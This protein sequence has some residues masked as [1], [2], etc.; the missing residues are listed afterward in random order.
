MYLC[1]VERLN[2]FRSKLDF[3]KNL[4]VAQESGQGPCT[5]VQCVWPNFVKND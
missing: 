4:K 1:C 3:F 2:Q 5:I